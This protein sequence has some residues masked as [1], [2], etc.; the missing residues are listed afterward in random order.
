[1]RGASSAIIVALA[2]IVS[3]PAVGQTSES[4]RRAASLRDKLRPGATV[5]L[6]DCHR[7]DEE[8]LPKWLA[9]VPGLSLVR[10]VEHLAVMK[11]S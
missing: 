7:R 4:C 10:E 5:M 8:T 1:M 3:R 9:E 6:N 11:I 2:T